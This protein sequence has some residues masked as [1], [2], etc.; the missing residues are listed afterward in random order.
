[1]S[2]A[3]QAAWPVLPLEL[4]LPWATLELQ[5]ALAPMGPQVPEGPQAPSASQPLL[6]GQEQL[7]PSVPVVPHAPRAAAALQRGPKALPAVR[8]GRQEAVVPRL[9]VVRVERLVLLCHCQ[10]AAP[11]AALVE[12]GVVASPFHLPREQPEPRG[13]EVP[14]EPLQLGAEPKEQLAGAVLPPVVVPGRRQSVVGPQ[15]G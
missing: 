11:L 2:P 1:M 15:G 13:L 4:A 3:Q 8:L 14:D 7:A 9:L 12:V 10:E 5:V 6:P